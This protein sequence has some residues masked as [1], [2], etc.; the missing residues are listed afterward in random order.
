MP[1]RHSELLGSAVLRPLAE[2][3][4]AAVRI[5]NGDV[6]CD[7]MCDGGV[8]SAELAPAVGVAGTLVAVDVERSLAESVAARHERA[9]KVFPVLSDGRSIALEDASCDAVVSLVSL[10]VADSMSLL[11]DAIR[12]LKPGG[13]V[14]VL[15]WDP[16]ALPPHEVLLARA[17]DESGLSSALLQ[18]LLTPVQ[19]PPPARAERVRDVARLQTFTHLWAAVRDRVE[20]AGLDSVAASR[21]ESVR[22]RYEEL[23]RRYAVADGTLVV[24]STALLIRL[25]R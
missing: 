14:A 18:R 3:L 20:D 24:P 13:V 15:V 16:S 21:R 5:R 12:V 8:L 23:M 10:A 6:V 19:P 25:S 4:L 11:R 9:C 7:L 2:Q 1:P 17:L 22:R